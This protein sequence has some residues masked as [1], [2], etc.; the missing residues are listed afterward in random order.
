ME[1][2]LTQYGLISMPPL[3]FQSGENSTHSKF[4][5]VKC[6]DLSQL[7]PIWHPPVGTV[8]CAGGKGC[9]RNGGKR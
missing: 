5:H 7:W 9:A 2:T 1:T 3:A 8:R 4:G 6:W